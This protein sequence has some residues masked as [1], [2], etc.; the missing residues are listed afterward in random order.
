[1]GVNSIVIIQI[2]E[3]EVSG[4]LVSRS[5]LQTR[6][7]SDLEAQTST[8]PDRFITEPGVIKFGL[9]DGG[10]RIVRDAKISTVKR[11]IGKQGY[12]TGY[13]E[14]DFRPRHG[15]VQGQRIIHL[16]PHAGHRSGWYLPVE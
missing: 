13:I 3:V 6:K 2:R 1:M 4:R 11:S 16:P 9:P 7:R 15:Q 5:C 14:I 8:E 10:P 12:A